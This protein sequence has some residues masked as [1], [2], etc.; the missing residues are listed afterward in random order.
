MGGR[1]EP[2]GW[3]S[4]RQIGMF[5]FDMEKCNIGIDIWDDIIGK[6][7]EWINSGIDSILFDKVLWR[8]SAKGNIV[9]S[10][11]TDV[12]EESKIRM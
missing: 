3:D 9:G 2:G 12:I 7:R 1:C 4:I 11:S 6:W 8:N 5:R 10:I